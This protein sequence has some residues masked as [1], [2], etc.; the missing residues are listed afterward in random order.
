MN[1]KGRGNKHAE[2]PVIATRVAIA[3]ASPA[4][5]YAGKAGDFAYGM[6]PLEPT[7]K[8]LAGIVAG[9]SAAIRSGAVRQPR[10]VAARA[11]VIRASQISD[12]PLI[13]TAIAVSASRSRRRPIVRRK[14]PF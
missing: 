3:A 4:I 13:T 14:M 2:M 10:P 6:V 12:V 8:R 7:Q 1:L 11:R 5:T 9:I